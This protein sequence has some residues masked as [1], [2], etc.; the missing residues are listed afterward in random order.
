MTAPGRT[1][2]WVLDVVLA[3][4]AAAGLDVNSARVSLHDG[5]DDGRARTVLVHLA[6]KDIAAGV[7]LLAAL[8]A[9]ATVSEPYGSPGSPQVNVDGI[10]PVLGGVRVATIAT[11]GLPAGPDSPQALAYAADAARSGMPAPGDVIPAGQAPTAPCS[12]PTTE[13]QEAE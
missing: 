6:R 12:A 1:P 3:A 8:G 2:G 5:G 7:E 13:R 11:E 9:P 10:V 4:A